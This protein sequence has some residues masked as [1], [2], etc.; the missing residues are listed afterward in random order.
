MEVAQRIQDELD[1]LR[2]AVAKREAEPICLA[3]LALRKAAAENG[4]KLAEMFERADEILSLSASDVIVSAFSH[5]HCFMCQDGAVSCKECKGTGFVEGGGK[6][7]VCDGLGSM[8]CDFCQGTG[9]AARDMIPPEIT[10][11]ILKRRQLANVKD[12][13]KGLKRMIDKLNAKKAG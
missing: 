4:V 6:C 9:W 7:P 11:D 12:D 8:P 5:R 3:Y 2:E 1:A 13:L 10:Q